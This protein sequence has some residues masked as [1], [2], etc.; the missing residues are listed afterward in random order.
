MC[1]PCYKLLSLLIL[2]ER[3]EEGI[4]FLDTGITDICEPPCRCWNP[5][6]PGF[7][8]E[9]QVLFSAEP[10]LWPTIL[11]IRFLALKGSMKRCMIRYSVC[12]S[13]SPSLCFHNSFYFLYQNDKDEVEKNKQTEQQQ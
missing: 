1:I 9:Q 12:S 10:S 11:I 3:P 8:Q 4:R 13:Q 7:L 5:K 2:L 6:S